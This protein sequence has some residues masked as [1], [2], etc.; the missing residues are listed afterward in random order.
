MM[1]DQSTGR[2]LL[3]LTLPLTLAWTSAF[4]LGLCLLAVPAARL[5]GELR[6]SDLDAGLALHATATYGLTWFDEH[7]IF[8]SELYDREEMRDAPYDIWLIEPVP[9]EED[10]WKESPEGDK[11]KESPRIHLAPELPRFDVQGLAELARDI[12]AA[13]REIYRDGRD[14]RGERYRLVAIPTFADENDDEA[15]AMIA[16]VGDPEP[17]HTAHRL[18]VAKIALITGL[19]ASAGLLVGM[20]LAR[21]SLRPALASLH[22]RESFVAAAAHELRN[23]LAALRGLCDGALAGDE[24]APAALRRMASLLDDASR[25]VDDL[26]LF[27]RLDAG[28]VKIERSKVRLDLLVEAVLPE[29]SAVVLTVEPCV[30]EVDPGLTAVAVRNLLANAC[31]HGGPRPSDVRVRVEEGEIVVDDHGPGFPEAILARAVHQVSVVASRRGSGLGLA[32]T[33]LV[34]G[35]H[36]GWLRLEN[37]PE[38]G[39]RATL[40]LA[41]DGFS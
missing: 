41:A 3:R 2:R 24:E 34:A 9:P 4:V 31:R 37:R 1:N 19:L 12:I 39:A 22:Q 28:T 17:G 13:P 8:H 36:G 7:G 26:L 10:K 21:W 15:L 18:F 29:D 35:L 5:E 14:R 11:W 33:A 23:P 25:T 16:V 38:G 30:V 32:I 20:V 6:R 27:T 40:R